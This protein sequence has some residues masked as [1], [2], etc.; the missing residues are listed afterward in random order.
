MRLVMMEARE[1]PAPKGMSPW[2]EEGPSA[3]FLDSITT[4]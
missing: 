4:Q 1:R 3:E 2:T